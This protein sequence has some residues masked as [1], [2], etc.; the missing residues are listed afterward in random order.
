[1]TE[2]TMIEGLKEEPWLEP[3]VVVF[4]EEQA[5]HRGP[6]GGF[7]RGDG[8]GSRGGRLGFAPR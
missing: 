7:D 5:V 3:F 8:V 1:M 6:N 2:Q 4:D